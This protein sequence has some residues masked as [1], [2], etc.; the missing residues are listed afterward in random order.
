MQKNL[1]LVAAVCSTFLALHA[2]AQFS[3]NVV[4]IGVLTDMSG[5]TADITGKG[6]LVAAQMAVQEFGSTVVG[7]PIEVISADHQHKTDLGASIARQW[8]DTEKVDVIVDVPNSSIALAV[9]G[10]AKQ[11]N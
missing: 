5:V 2:N 3:D 4:K 7:K 8:Y 10:I 11:S 9:Q 1:K 6:S